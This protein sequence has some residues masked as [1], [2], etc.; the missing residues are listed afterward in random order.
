MDPSPEECVRPCRR[1]LSRRTD[2]KQIGRTLKVRFHSATTLPI[3]LFT[4]VQCCLLALCSLGSIKNKVGPITSMVIH[5]VTCQ[6]KKEKERRNKDTADSKNLRF[7]DLSMVLN[8]ALVRE[9]SHKSEKCSNISQ[10]YSFEI[11]SSGSKPRFLGVW[12]LFWGFSHYLGGSS[13]YVRGG[14]VVSPRN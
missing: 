7:P 11:F 2:V 3:I 13:H 10:Q 8:R 6:R 4:H 9:V 5:P 12:S 1:P 14:R